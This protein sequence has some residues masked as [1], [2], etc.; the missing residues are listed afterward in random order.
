MKSSAIAD[1]FTVE[2]T[3]KPARPAGKPVAAKTPAA[4]PAAP[5]KRAPAAKRTVSKP[6]VL[7]VEVTPAPEAVSL[8]PDGLRRRHRL[9][10]T[11]VGVAV[12]VAA[13]VA[14]FLFLRGDDR[15]NQSL[16]GA[17][18]AVSAERLATLAS[19]Q[20]GP[21]YWA[22]PIS[23][24]K[25]EL[26]TTGSGTFVRYLPLSTSVGDS[27]RAITVATYPLRNAFATAVS[28]SKSPQMTSRETAAGGLVVWSRT[29]PTSVYLAFPGVPHLV[30]VYAPDAVQART[31]A[32]SG[33]IR[34]VR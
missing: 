6:T 8:S 2:R 17:P 29:R 23:A 32:L 25:L 15:S 7:P 16:A 30:E 28:R 27:G 5:R 18:A 22:G 12:L 21:V 33:R 4:K 24:R 13:T 19:S 20:A 11:S 1:T 31:L 3:R 26:T 9:A 34:P 10:F 14:G